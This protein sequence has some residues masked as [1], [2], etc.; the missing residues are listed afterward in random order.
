MLF[1]KIPFDG[2]PT[3]IL[4]GPVNRNFVVSPEGSKEMVCIIVAKIFDAK[5]INTKAKFC[6]ASI[7][8]PKSGCVRA[9][10]VSMRSQLINQV[11]V[12]EDGLQ[13]IHSF[14]DLDVDIVVRAEQGI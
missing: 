10:I 11:F 1:W 7:V 3:V 4:P 9:R 8:F 5:I 14:F 12:R 6:W 2:K 13:A